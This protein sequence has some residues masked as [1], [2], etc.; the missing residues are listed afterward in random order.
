MEAGVEL[1]PQTS[2]LMSS[3]H[4]LHGTLPFITIYQLINVKFFEL[5]QC[6]T[7]Y[8]NS[9]IYAIICGFVFYSLYGYSISSKKLN[10]HHA[11]ESMSL[12]I[13]ALIFH[14]KQRIS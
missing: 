12:F 3:F 8:D 5:P 10:G 7:V 6:F 4:P 9:L 13:G 11:F 14:L 1:S 2:F